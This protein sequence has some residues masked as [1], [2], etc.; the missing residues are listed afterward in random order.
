MLALFLCHYS[1]RIA[2][3][4]GSHTPWNH[5]PN[6][7]GSRLLFEFAIVMK[8]VKEYI[9]KFLNSSKMKM[10]QYLIALIVLTSLVLLQ[11]HHSLIFRPRAHWTFTGAYADEYIHAV[12]IIRKNTP[13]AHRILKPSV[14][15]HYTS[16]WWP[17]HVE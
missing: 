4:S 14:K 8:A 3:K 5:M 7:I 12:P 15:L 17:P 11:E 9:P 1:I 10:N 6:E 13:G 2:S 16:F